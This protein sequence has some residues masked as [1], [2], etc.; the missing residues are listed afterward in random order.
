MIAPM[1]LLA[2]VVAAAGAAVWWRRIVRCEHDCSG[3]DHDSQEMF[4][5][6]E[7]LFALALIDGVDARCHCSRFTSGDA[8]PQY[9]LAKTCIEALVKE[10][11][12]A[13]VKQLL[14]QARGSILKELA[15]QLA[16]DVS[17]TE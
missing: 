3:V 5:R 8:S 17:N 12:H 15:Q 14:A 2:G 4:R 1:I 10:G 11:Q 9:A 13:R 16:D 7:L 6:G